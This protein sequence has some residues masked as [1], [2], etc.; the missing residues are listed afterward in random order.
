[1]PFALLATVLFAAPPQKLRPN[2]LAGAHNL[3][4][5]HRDRYDA[6]GRQHHGPR[7]R[8]CRSGFLGRG[9]SRPA[10]AQVLT[11]RNPKR[12]NLV[13]RLHGSG[14]HKP[15]PDHLPP[16]RRRSEARG[17]EPRPLRLHREGR[18]L[19]YGRG[20]QDMKNSDAVVVGRAAAAEERSLASSPTATSSWR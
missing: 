1:M 6:V 12:G 8:R 5:A 4:A 9:P 20:T 2:P 17:L 15:F 16:R 18:L 13:A 10:D 3:Q 14:K 11:G 7:R 19:L